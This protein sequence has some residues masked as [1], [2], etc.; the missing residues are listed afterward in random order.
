MENA[1]LEVIPDSQ[2][3]LQRYQDLYTAQQHASP[4]AVSTFEEKTPEEDVEA[5]RSGDARKKT[6]LG[7]PITTLALITTV[8]ILL[9]AALATVGSL[10][11]IRISTVEQDFEQLY[12][13]LA[14]SVA[15]QSGS[16]TITPAPSGTNAPADST[17]K[18]V[19]E[20]PTVVAGYT[21]QGCFHD[22]ESRRVLGGARHNNNTD[23]DDT[24]LKVTNDLCANLCRDYKYFGTENGDM[25]FCGNEPAF[26]EPVP[27][28]ACNR[29]CLGNGNTF[30]MCGGFSAMNLY[31]KGAVD[32][33]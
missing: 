1:G 12:R 25:C 14:Y 20:R 7:L 6:F 30:E 15:A 10:F 9:V 24:D 2:P 4:N 19:W 16:L 28:W 11:G 33:E 21:Y 13:Q 17:D 3:G 5:A 31:K 23:N 32:E 18:I 8:F 27:V 22:T 26:T 29:Q